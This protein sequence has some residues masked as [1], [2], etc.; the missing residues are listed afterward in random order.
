MI[1]IR[2]G[3]DDTGNAMREHWLVEIKGWEIGLDLWGAHAASHVRVKGRVEMFE[4][5][6]VPWGR[7]RGVEANI[8]DSEMLAGNGDASGV[9]LIYEGEVLGLSRHDGCGQWPTKNVHGLV[10]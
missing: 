4:D 10:K 1:G 2:V 7:G 3:F 8:F 5:Y 9:L 6:S